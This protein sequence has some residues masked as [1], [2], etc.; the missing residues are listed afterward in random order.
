MLHAQR[1]I[2]VACSIASLGN[3]DMD[4]QRSLRCLADGSSEQ[5]EATLMVQLARIQQIATAWRD[6]DRQ[7]LPPTG[8]A[9]RMAENLPGTQWLPFTSQVTCVLQCSASRWLCLPHHPVSTL[10]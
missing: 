7:E 6:A 2:I 1:A 5:D 9:V 8:A 4:W 10:G 3:L